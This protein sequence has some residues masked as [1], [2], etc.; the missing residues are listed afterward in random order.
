MREKLI[1]LGNILKFLEDIGADSSRIIGDK[2]KVRHFS[3]SEFW[4]K[5]AFNV[6]GSGSKALDGILGGLNTIDGADVDLAVGEVT[7]KIDLNDGDETGD[8][9]ILEVFDDVS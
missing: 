7:G 3:E 2:L 4:T 6:T 8:S 9:G 5:F 1:R